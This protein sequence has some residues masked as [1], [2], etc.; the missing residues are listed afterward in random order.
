MDT[1][2]YFAVTGLDYLLFTA[3]VGF[4]VANFS[5]AFASPL[6]AA[7]LARTISSLPLPSSLRALGTE[8]PFFLASASAMF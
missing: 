3:F 7:S 5:G 1:S 2:S 4:G 6:G 8:T